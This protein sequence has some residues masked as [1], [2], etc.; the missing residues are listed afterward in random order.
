MAA[1]DDKIEVRCPKCDHRLRF[2]Q[3][4]VGR[5]GLCPLCE[6]SFRIAPPEQSPAPPPAPADDK[7]EAWKISTYF[8]NPPPK[9]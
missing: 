3:K 9:K 1:P 6:A 5:N 7:S 8:R 4:F 2:A